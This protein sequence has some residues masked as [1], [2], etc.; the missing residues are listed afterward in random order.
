MVGD[1]VDQGYDV[2]DFLGRFTQ[3]LDP[4]GGFLDLLTDVVHAA[5]GV[6]YH[7]RAFL[8]DR[9]R[10]FRNRGG[11][12]RVGRYLVDGHGH[13]V[14]SGRGAGN[15]LGLVLGSIRQVHCCGL[16]FLGG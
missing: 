3:T 9:N 5:D 12:S 14:H 13:L 10:P 15:F 4:F 16:G 8:R 2:T 1:V 11:F 7:F 6:L